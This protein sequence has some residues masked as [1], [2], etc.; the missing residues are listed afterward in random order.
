MYPKNEY[1]LPLSGDVAKRGVE[2]PPR[3]EEIARVVE[4]FYGRIAGDALLGPI[5][6][7]RVGDW[8]RHLATMR[9]F[10]SSAIFRTGRYRGRPLEVHR[11]LGGLGREHFER[12]LALWEEAVN[13]VVSDG[14]AAEMIE[15]GHRMAESMLMRLEMDRAPGG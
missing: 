6:G 1:R 14:M 4:L 7:A 12:W 5:F 3:E 9:D 13:E 10:W 15:M 2:G 8:D 11:R